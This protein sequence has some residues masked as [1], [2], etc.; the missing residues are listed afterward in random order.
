MPGETVFH[1]KLKS[2]AVAW[3]RNQGYVITAP[4]VA[5]P[6]R[7]YRVD[8]AACIPA[9]K[10]PPRK[11]A[12]IDRI[13]QT[14]VIFECK[15]SR[16]DLIKDNKRQEA[17]RKQLDS[18]LDRKLKLEGL[19]QVHLPHLARGESLFPQFDSYQFEDHDHKVYRQV[20][21]QIR[22]TQAALK[23]KLKFDTIFRYRIANLHYLVVEEGLLDPHEVP[24]GWGV[25]ERV[26]DGLTLRTKPGWQD[27]ELADQLLFLQRLAARR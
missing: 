17:T 16:G 25:L 12:P 1:R 19:L 26:G 9:M 21:R 15:A 6:H 11:P 10:A 4:E 18:L 27:I 5:F 7:R 24:I 13:L 3:A 20:T 2:L 14:A 8:V 22:E 23:F